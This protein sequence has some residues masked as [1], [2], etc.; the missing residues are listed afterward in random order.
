MAARPAPGETVIDACA[1]GGGKILALADM[2]RG[3]GTFH[4]CD[5]DA[6]R[7]DELVR[8]AEPL[9]LRSLT[10]HAIAPEG[11]LPRK[12][13]RHADLV[14]VDAPCSGLGSLRRNPDLKQ[15]YGERDVAE[16]ARLQRG[17]LE[18]FA[19]HVRP[20]GRLVYVT[21]SILPDENE[22]VVG[23]LLR[24]H[25]ELRPEPP[26]IAERLPPA[27]LDGAWLRLGP[28]TTGT[29]GFFVACLRRE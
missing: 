11:E 3:E 13:P 24:E 6:S 21:C 2:A 12:L 23:G 16:F 18:R 15:R 26:P 8:R 27:A 19:A 28:D 22:A 29:D 5:V 9:G 7:L 17:I 4:A 20:G 1:G 10:V 25:R 14:L